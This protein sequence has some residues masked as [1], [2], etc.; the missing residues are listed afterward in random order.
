MDT[1][2]YTAIDRAGLQSG[3][4]V[5]V[6]GITV[7]RVDRIEVGPG[8]SDGDSVAAR[9]T[10]ML[11]ERFDVRADAEVE[12]ASSLTGTA[13]LNFAD[14]GSGDAADADT[15]LEGQVQSLA[16]IIDR[17]ESLV[18]R[19]EQT[20]ASFDSAA[21]TV[22]TLATDVTA[23]TAELRSTLKQSRADLASAIA[24][25]RSVGTTLE[26]RLPPTLDR[27]DTLLNDADNLVNRA[28]QSLDRLDPILEG[29]SEVGD[30]VADVRGLV[31]DIDTLVTENRRKVSAL[32][33]DL[34]STARSAEGAVSEIR[35]AP[36]RLLYKP[37]DKDQR[38]LALYSVARQY[39]EAAQDLERAAAL[40][41][42]ARNDGAPAELETVEAEVRAAF[43]RFDAVQARL[44][45]SLER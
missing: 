29:L 41:E 11:P 25:A 38:N 14:T 7:G 19:V 16:S 35:A 15:V 9:V 20:L 2:D 31:G 10:I 28:R 13:W 37:K 26:E 23:L 40:L 27:A 42:Q 21:G 6:L 12:A 43:N 30:T 33:D 24:S 1:F 8:Q 34:A 4:D 36:W 32:L 22:D 44:W 3:A 17:A 45:E 5:R 39:A 18:P